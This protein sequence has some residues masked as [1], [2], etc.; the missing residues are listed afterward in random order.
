MGLLHAGVDTTVIALFAP[1]CTS[2]NSS[3][4]APTASPA[5]RRRWRRLRPRAGQRRHGDRHWL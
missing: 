3:P 2:A 5:P 4:A 1:G